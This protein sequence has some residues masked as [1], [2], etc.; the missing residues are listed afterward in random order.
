MTDGEEPNT[1]V[2]SLPLTSPPPLPCTST[3]HGEP[4][5]SSTP[6][7]LQVKWSPG[8]GMSADN[9]SSSDADPQTVGL[10]NPASSPSTVIYTYPDM[11]K[12][13]RGR[14]PTA[15]H[16]C[17]RRKQKCDGNVPCNNC[18]KRGPELCEYTPV[19]ALATFE[20]EPEGSSESQKPKRKR[21]GKG[22][23]A[24]EGSIGTLRPSSP[25][26]GWAGVNGE[27]EVAQPGDPGDLN[28]IAHF[29]GFTTAPSQPGENR[30]ILNTPIHPTS[31]ERNRQDTIGD[32]SSSSLTSPPSNANPGRFWRAHADIQVDTEQPSMRSKGSGSSSESEQLME[33]NEAYGV[34]SMRTLRG[35]RGNEEGE[36]TFFGTSHFGPQLAAKVIRSTPAF[37][38][39][40]V[41]HGPLY[42]TTRI[43]NTKSYTL[44]SQTRELLSHVPPREECDLYV[45]RFFE[46]FNVHN[47][48]VYEPDFNS[49]YDKLWQ[50][51][52]GQTRYDLDL[53]QL[54]LLLIILAFG[55]LL[56]HDPSDEQR[57]GDKLKTIGLTEL[58]VTAVSGM[59]HDLENQSLSL[60]DREEKSTKWSWAARRALSESASFFGES[61][62]TIRAGI[63]MAHYLNV[64]RRVEEA[65]TAIGTAIRAAQAQGLHVDGKS[66]KGMSP[67]E[68]ELRRRLWAH[69]YIVDRSISLFLGR[70]VCIQDGHFTT[71]ESSNLHDE[72]LDRPPTPRSL[73]IPTKS[74][75]LILHFR[76][77]RIISSVQLTC[78]NLNPRRYADVQYCEELFLEFKQ[79][80]PPHFRLDNEGTDLSLDKDGNYKWLVAQRQTLNSKFHLARISLHRPYLLRSF[81][82][83][84][85]NG[86]NPYEGSREALVQSALAD[87]RLRISLNELDPLDRFKWT[88][89]AS[90]FNPATIVGILCFLGYQ[91]ERFRPGELRSVLQAYIK[92]EEKTVRRDET[93][94][95]ELRVLRLMEGKALAREASDAREEL[96]K[97]SVLMSARAEYAQS[98]AE[99]V[100]G[101]S[102]NHSHALNVPMM[103]IRGYDS[104]P[105]LSQQVIT[106]SQHGFSMYHGPRV[107]T[108][109]PHLDDGSSDMAPT[110]QEITQGSQSYQLTGHVRPHHLRRQ[111]VSAPFH[112]P[113]NLSLNTFAEVS[114]S[115]DWSF[116]NVNTTMQSASTSSSHQSPSTTLR[117]PDAPIMSETLSSSMDVVTE[118]SGATAASVAGSQEWAVPSDW[119]PTASGLPD[120]N[121]TLGWIALFETNWHSTDLD[122]IGPAVV[123][124]D[125]V[126]RTAYE[127]GRSGV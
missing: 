116:P 81:G 126:W 13:R 44:E 29:T 18:L 51:I 43:D 106:Q 94:E 86:K 14:L 112:G 52:N 9:P 109:H 4:L 5:E 2:S 64:C 96:S 118:I 45:R 88:T 111:T 6:E 89:V 58:Q 12:R 62:D 91:D 50:L 41:R 38:H 71:R 60:K 103:A 57:R 69:L 101:S 48:I 100:T 127:N 117:N 67:K 16:E 27:G 15:C 31:S 76:L 121:D 125:G 28:S 54:A 24:S 32:R 123:G 105:T 34:G 30:Y 92:L 97:S 87:L 82:R 35:P 3:A 49:S 22:A 1:D 115:Q 37:P 53:R 63:L 113:A 75:F 107:H 73:T 98:R 61:I 46:R 8:I 68:A 80:L 102:T 36:K 55:V 114:P 21:G 47:D 17:N 42:G 25:R 19:S 72:E 23:R 74:T 59:M 7:P 66:W 10:N 39:S 11:G 90:G 70:P 110:R 79:N 124:S 33:E 99:P 120:S 95:T 78:F 85:D 104:Q 77:A 56:D 93:L 108:S 40:D 26:S 20:L 84:K 65:W 119:D 122:P 83:G